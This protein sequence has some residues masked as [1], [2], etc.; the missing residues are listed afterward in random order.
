MDRNT[1][2]VSLHACRRRW[3]PLNYTPGNRK[4]ANQNIDEYCLWR[5]R[6]N[7]DA[8]TVLNRKL[9]IALALSEWFLSIWEFA[10]EDILGYLR[11]CKNIHIHICQSCPMCILYILSYPSSIS[12]ENIPDDIQLWYPNYIQIDPFVSKK[13]ICFRYSWC[14]PIWL[15]WNIL[16][17][18]VLYPETISMMISNYDVLVISKYIHVYPILISILDILGVIPWSLVFI[19]LFL[20]GVLFCLR[21]FCSVR[22]L[23]GSNALPIYLNILSY[24]FTHQR[25]KN[26]ILSVSKPAPC[27]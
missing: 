5:T 7:Q 4:F 14:Y 25:G 1:W 21:F 17:I 22:L 12:R 16:F 6:R 18:L 23:L 10:P 27:A 2:H 9:E 20:H 15:S 3:V 24:P 19:L 13:D 8:L 11:I 26:C